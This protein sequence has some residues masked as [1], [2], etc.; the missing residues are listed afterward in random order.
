[1]VDKIFLVLNEIEGLTEWSSILE[2][3][4]NYSL[5]L[6]YAKDFGTEQRSKTI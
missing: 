3:I 4:K 2:V 6:S 1:M 5:V